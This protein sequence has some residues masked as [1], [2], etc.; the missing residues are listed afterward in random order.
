M[1]TILLFVLVHHLIIGGIGFAIGYAVTRGKA[2]KQVVATPPSSHRE[3]TSDIVLAE[4]ER[5]DVLAI[6]G[7]DAQKRLRD[8]YQ[9]PNMEQTTPRPATERRAT[10]VAQAT[11]A[12]LG[13]ALS[14]LSM[15]VADSGSTPAPAMAKPAH[16]IPRPAPRREVRKRTPVQLDPALVLLY[17][18][19]FLI[20]TAGLIYAS[21]NW[22][23][24]E[25]AQRLG[26]LTASTLAFVLVG[27]LLLPN[28]RLRPAGETF[29]GIGALLIPSNIIATVTILSGTPLRAT[30]ALQI[31]AA[32]A[33]LLY[34]FFSF[35]PGSAI[36]RY[37]AAISATIAI[38]VLPASLGAHRSWA[39]PMIALAPS[40]LLAIID[41]VG[42]SAQRFWIPT[43]QAAP[44]VAALAVVAP[45]V[46]GM[47]PG[48]DEIVI[49]A[50]LAGA[51]VT[52]GAFA[53]I[54]DHS[55]LGTGALVIALASVALAASWLDIEAARMTLTAWFGV[56]MLMLVTY[57]PR[58]YH[59]TL[60]PLVTVTS[61][62]GF[63]LTLMAPGIDGWN[64]SSWSIGS[65]FGLVAVG[66]ALVAVVRH[67][68]WLLTPSLVLGFIAHVGALDLLELL[69]GEEWTIPLRLLPGLIAAVALPALIRTRGTLD[70]RRRQ[71]FFL[72]IGFGVLTVPLGSMTI[73]DAPQD[74]PV[75][76]MVAVGFLLLFALAAIVA[77]QQH[78]R[79]LA[80]VAAAGWLVSAAVTALAPVPLDEVYRWPM[81][82]GAIGLI[83]L[84]TPVIEGRAWWRRVR[85]LRWPTL[86]FTVAAIVAASPMVV[87]AIDLIAGIRTLDESPW[88]L[89][90]TSIFAGAALVLGWYTLYRHPNVL[91]TLSAINAILA[92]GLALRAGV[93]TFQPDP[94]IWPAIGIAL[95]LIAALGAVRLDDTESGMAHRWSGWVA[96]VSALIL[97]PSL[98]RAVP[99]TVAYIASGWADVT[100]EHGDEPRWWVP[101]LFALIALTLT[102]HVIGKHRDSTL[103]SVA[104][105]IFG[106]FTIALLTR[107]ITTDLF[108]LTI[109]GLL[110][111][112]AGTALA[113]MLPRGSASRY[114][115]GWRS[116]ARPLQ[117]VAAIS[118]VVNATA[119]L[120][121]TIG[122]WRNVVL[123]SGLAA[124]AAIASVRLRKPTMLYASTSSLGMAVLFVLLSPQVSALDGMLIPVAISWILVAISIAPKLTGRWARPLYSSGWV[125]GA[126]PIVYA[127]SR[128]QQMWEGDSS[129]YQ[130]GTVAILS[131]SL[132]IGL[133]ALVRRSPARGTAAVVLAMAAAIRQVA[134]YEPESL[135]PYAIVLAATLAVIGGMWHRWPSRSSP[136]Y[137]LAGVV[138][139]G[140]PLV[141]SFT[142]GGTTD[143]FIAGGYA[144]L[145]VGLGLIVRRQA[146]V[147]VGVI[148]VTLVVLRQLVDTARAFESW[149]IL[150]GAGAIL[151]IGGTLILAIRDTFR[152]W[153]ESAREFW[154]TLR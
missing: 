51:A 12:P 55:L 88:W 31:G 79:V 128:T 82:A 142:I 105:A 47:P 102:G 57:G 135:Q 113:Q 70:A 67:W 48:Q 62:L 22:D 56:S 19:A 114:L 71:S 110:I 153:I 38:G 46:V 72:W 1:E 100:I 60:A 106:I 54:R 109:A 130:R 64:D 17:L 6:I 66:W 45:P 118:L 149:Q 11:T 143:A 107:M 52:V 40:L 21:F 108:V 42:P 127:A 16:S 137:A 3:R 59:T 4:I 141:E 80:L 58:L 98:G 23:E 112:I 93:D 53:A 144:L 86:V 145:V 134:T 92:I 28:T 29:I 37:A 126:V 68:W 133:T 43:L 36:Y 138:L 140:V 103:C 73:Q 15:P 119:G 33:T 146:P 116:L 154:A 104:T 87:L 131:L 10:D 101:T 69:D 94:L 5:A 99:D 13:P 34:T 122:P 2:R 136:L 20:V 24:L 139:V 120:D 90:Y 35:R 76:R 147:A 25:G 44:V 151:L 63:G 91:T 75:S 27:M 89:G 152:R 14:E 61:I 81:F 95:A 150:A 125:F 129:I 111:G 9:S 7:A 117:L 97:L 18:G 132:A 115:Q 49:A 74:E 83:G 78:H 41:R 148:G 124:V 30:L 77:A 65:A 26:L 84:L 39:L 121:G 96:V 123:Y 50:V 85:A 8:F 32:L